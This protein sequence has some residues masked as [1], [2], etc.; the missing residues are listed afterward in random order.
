M[1]APF[2]GTITGRSS[3]ATLIRAGNDQFIRQLYAR[4][5]PR[6]FYR[7]RL[8]WLVKHGKTTSYRRLVAYLKRAGIDILPHT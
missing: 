2:R 8:E 3:N 7:R 4:L 6:E 1:P 5:G